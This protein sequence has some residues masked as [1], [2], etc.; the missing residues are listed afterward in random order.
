MGDRRV[1]QYAAGRAG[2]VALK[3]VYGPHCFSAQNIGRLAPHETRRAHMEDG[4]SKAC[5]LVEP[6]GGAE[7]VGVV[8]LSAGVDA[9]RRPRRRLVPS[10]SRLRAQRS[11]CVA[12]IVAGDRL[13]EGGRVAG[14]KPTAPMMTGMITCLLPRDSDEVEE[15][16]M[17]TEDVV[18]LKVLMRSLLRPCCDFAVVRGILTGDGLTRPTWR[19]KVLRHEQSDGND[20]PKVRSRAILWS[21]SR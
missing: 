20:E 16:P 7:C 21:F 4:V 10:R 14:S 6:A 8:D 1:P 3:P 19:D 12:R 15:L 9:R 17:S 13:D 11:G 5:T 2:P 18:A